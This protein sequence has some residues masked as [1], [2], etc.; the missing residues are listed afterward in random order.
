MSDAPAGHVS[1][2]DGF[3]DAPLSS[4]LERRKHARK[5]L[6]EASAV[7]LDGATGSS[8]TIVDLSEG[9]VGV[10]SE[11]P[12]AASTTCRLQLSF[13]NS[14][15]VVD[16]ACELA[17]T[18]APHAGFRFSILTEKC[19]RQIKAWLRALE[20]G[21][22]A[23]T[24]AA[25]PETTAEPLPLATSSAVATQHAVL[26][27]LSDDTL[28]SL[29]LQ[30]REVAGADGAAVAV[31]D[32]SAVIC[33]ASVGSAPDV[34]ARIQPDT[35]LSGECLRSGEIVACYDTET[36][37]RVDPLVA[38]EL[39]MRSAVILPIGR[40][41]MPAGLLEVFFAREHAFDE[42]RIYALQELASEFL[43][44]SHSQAA[45][46]PTEIPCNE[47]SLPK[48]ASFTQR[49][50]A[51]GF[52]M[53]DVCGHDNHEGN[54]ACEKC[55]VPL[56]SALR[57]VDL[58]SP[59][60]LESAGLRPERTQVELPDPAHR[61]GRGKK[62]LLMLVAIVLVAGWQARGRISTDADLPA[63]PPMPKPVV[64]P[65][66]ERPAAKREKILDAPPARAAEPEVTVRN[67][68]PAK[69]RASKSSP[70]TPVARKVSLQNSTIP[71]AL[72]QPVSSTTE[73]ASL[74]QQAIVLPLN[75]QAAL[76]AL[77]TPASPVSKQPQ[78][79]FWKRLGK[80]LVPGKAKPA[81][82]KKQ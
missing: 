58:N 47:H 31:S 73:P 5:K 51:P 60:E 25:E 71:E 43:L 16:A 80:K 70:A 3:D 20:G 64:A 10:R 68:L 55:D 65:A 38:R 9:G 27:G 24:A 57:Y 7:L 30:A 26:A 14:N 62:L 8:A 76:A 42:A 61:P 12:L 82:V 78:S 56:P 4:P 63:P 69:P 1:L 22:N 49:E 23:A 48:L 35:G 34:G 2:P 46:P 37:G 74:P 66:L 77:A 52:V 53:C 11:S 6:A 54:R 29:A 15:Q 67:F 13:P 21:S 50:A 36:D 18:R 19:H 17:W 45:P 40:H 72:P 39:N 79:S 33:R 59:I 32:G 28:L 44:A 81:D 75:D 41:D